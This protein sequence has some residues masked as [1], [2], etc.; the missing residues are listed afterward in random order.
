MQDSSSFQEIAIGVRS[1]CTSRVLQLD[2]LA[3]PGGV[4]VANG[5]RVSE[6]LQ[7]EVA[8]QQNLSAR[9]SQG[10]KRMYMAKGAYF[11]NVISSAL[12]RIHV[13]GSMVPRAGHGDLA[14]GIDEKTHDALRCL[15]LAL[16]EPHTYIRMS[17]I[18][19]Q[20]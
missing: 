9:R 15:G 4:V 12:Q 19:A 1:G 5:L 17:Q 10:W 8:L 2:V 16:R 11:P 13:L 6:G 18:P 7:Y 3:E 14:V 20:T